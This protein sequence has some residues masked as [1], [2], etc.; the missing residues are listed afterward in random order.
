MITRARVTLFWC[1]Y[2]SLHLC[3]YVLLVSTVT[4]K[5][6]QNVILYIT[7]VKAVINVHIPDLCSAFTCLIIFPFLIYPMRKVLDWPHHQMYFF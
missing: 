6:V 7:L 3:P 4:L 1:R 2:P 5:S